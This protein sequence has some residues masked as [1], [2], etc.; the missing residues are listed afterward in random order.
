MVAENRFS[1]GTRMTDAVIDE[2]AEE[3]GRDV[4]HFLRAGYY[5]P[6]R[7]AVIQPLPVEESAFLEAHGADFTA[8]S[9][10]VAEQRARAHALYRAIV[11]TSLGPEEVRQ[12]LNVSGSRLRQRVQDGS[13]Y[14]LSE[15][16]S[17]VYPLFQFTDSGVL[18]GLAEVL[19]A[20]G[21]KPHPLVVVQFFD[22]PTQDLQI[23][24]V[25]GPVSPRDFLESGGDVARVV[26]LALDV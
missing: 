13:L 22:T 21:P 1:G 8:N 3:V 15:D 20:L 12:H 25:D 6:R 17:R 5:D 26:R 11:K 24:G 16:S 7:P 23:P 19:K 2:I 10:A 18:P 4:R 14:V 9:R